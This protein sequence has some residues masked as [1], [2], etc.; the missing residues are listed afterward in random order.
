MDEN[1]RVYVDRLFN[2]AM[3]KIFKHSTYILTLQINAV[4]LWIAVIL[5]SLHAFGLI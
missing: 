1:G 2:Y 4:L 5:L 3:E